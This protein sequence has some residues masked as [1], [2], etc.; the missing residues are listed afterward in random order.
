MSSNGK[1]KRRGGDT[2]ISLLSAERTPVGPG[3]EQVVLQTDRGA[4]RGFLH[5]AGADGAP[6]PAVV[7]WVGGAGGGTEGPAGGIYHRLADQ[8]ALEGISSLRLDYRHPNVLVECIADV[9][10]GLAW[11]EDAGGARRAS[12][13]GHSFGG[14]VV[15][16]AGALNPIVKDVIA[17]SSQTYGADLVGDVSPRTLLLVHGEADR[18]LPAA[19]SRQ[20][21]AAAQ[22]PRELVLYPGCGHGLDECAP[23]LRDLLLTHIRLQL[24][25]QGG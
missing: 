7:V 18:V 2:T 4:I 10:V 24:A 3:V 20:L 9:L 1:P 23:A 11:L 21:Y 6:G 17:L 12:L 15:I 16:D 13:V 25:P 14:A 5:A 19:C 22:D 8:L